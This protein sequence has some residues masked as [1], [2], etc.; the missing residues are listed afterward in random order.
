MPVTLFRKKKKKVM[1]AICMAL[2]NLLPM[3]PGVFKNVRFSLCNFGK[4]V[5]FVLMHKR[6]QIFSETC[7]CMNGP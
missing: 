7:L 2:S 3:E 6:K 1:F 5:S 4:C